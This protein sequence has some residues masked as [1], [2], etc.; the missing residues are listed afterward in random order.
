MSQNQFSQQSL[1]L[2]LPDMNLPDN[3]FANFEEISKKYN[4]ID[5]KMDNIAAYENIIKNDSF[6]DI[7]NIKFHNVNNNNFIKNK[8]N[9]IGFDNAELIFDSPRA[10]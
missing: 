1:N 10:L 4:D 9:K 6:N 7:N 3:F 8:N 5:I 2:N